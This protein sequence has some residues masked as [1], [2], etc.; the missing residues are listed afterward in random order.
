MANNIPPIISLCEFSQ[1][2]KGSKLRGQI[3]PKFEL[4]RDFM[5]VVPTC[6][7]EEDPIKNEGTRLL[8]RVSPS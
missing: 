3:W 5:V 2:L 8:T 6:I 4:V 1:T 7:N